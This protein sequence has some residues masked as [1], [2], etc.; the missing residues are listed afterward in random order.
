MAVPWAEAFPVVQHFPPGE[1]VE[2][3]AGTEVA[4]HPAVGC[5]V[6]VISCNRT[7]ETAQFT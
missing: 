4:A 6:R 1:Q 7:L 2:G 5:L 3:R